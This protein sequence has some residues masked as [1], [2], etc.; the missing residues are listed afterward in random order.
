M[1]ELLSKKSALSH[2]RA[3]GLDDSMK[4][5]T[6]PANVLELI[7]HFLHSAK[8]GFLI[9]TVQDNYVVKIEKTEKFIIAAK[10]REE[11]YVQY[12]RPLKKHPLQLKIV[13]ELREIQYGQLV[14]RLTNGHVDLMEKTEKHRVNEVE[15]IH[16]DGI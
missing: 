2:P 10:N 5:K 13:D 15:G 7:N 3:G 16:G 4:L 8:N 6:I 12:E 11:N 14:V 9:L 1:S